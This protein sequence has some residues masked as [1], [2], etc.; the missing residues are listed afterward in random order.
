MDKLRRIC[1]SGYKSLRY[2]EQ[3]FELP[4]EAAAG[5]HCGNAIEFG[6][7]TV[8]LGANGAGKSNIVSFFKLLN[9]TTT[10][11]LQE[12]I[13]R[14]GGSDSLLHYGRKITPKMRLELEFSASGDHVGYEAV[15]ADAAPD[16]LVFTDEKILY[17]RSGCMESHEIPLGSGH[18][19]SR[20]KQR[21]S[22]DVRPTKTLLEMFAGC[23][24]YQFHDTSS[25]A[26]IRKAGYIEDGAYLR[27]D[28]GNL[29]A[30]L[31]AMMQTNR[32]YY[33]RIVQTIRKV[34]PQFDGF[35]LEP[36]P[37]NENYILLNWREKG[38]AEYLF[39]PHQLSDGS[40]RF[41]ALAALFLQPKLPSVIVIDEPELGLHPHAVTVLASM[42][43][44]A[45]QHCQV[46]LSTQSTRLV[47]EFDVEEI[48]IV[49]R[50]GQTNCTEF[51]RPDAEQLAD[52]IDRYS[53]SE[54]WEKN[55]LGGLP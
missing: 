34:F 40:L 37:R 49:E 8:L 27:S 33:D 52:W 43:H 44:S 36:S 48:V 5:T 18:R 31:L 32:P 11:A 30:F 7:V 3:D 55:V 17:Q 12:Y 6:D 46:I 28:G 45:A 4:A 23:R 42:I 51:R 39:G 14:E 26:D 15:L 2:S 13:G 54:L 50:N 21:E 41:M 16:T 20:L 9:F 35:V 47:D 38:K 22:D 10:G 29:A 19:E 24:T 53:T 25:R 1:L